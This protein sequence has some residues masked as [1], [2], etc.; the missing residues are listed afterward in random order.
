MV[1]S[2]F[3]TSNPLF[4]KRTK[5]KNKVLIDERFKSVLT[6][7]K[8]LSVPGRVDKYGRKK[9]SDKSKENEL[10][11]FYEIEKE[12][13]QEPS[14]L[15]KNNKLDRDE[16]R[17]DYLT[18]LARGEIENS[19]SDEES[20]YDMTHDDDDTND[21]VPSSSNDYDDSSPNIGPLDIEDP[22]TIEKGE[23]TYRLALQN[24]DWEN[25]TARDMM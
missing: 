12:S 14:R 23:A 16:D 2:R 15:S 20:D 11:E 17:L 24:F 4:K 25:L 9:K 13:E 8:F 21:E 7:N 18:K 22:N 5:K 3:D 19:S 10:S 1:D 6:E